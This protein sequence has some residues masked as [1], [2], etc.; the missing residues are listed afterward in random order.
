ML[1]DKHLLKEQPHP[2]GYIGGVQRIYRFDNGY[3]LSV[4][5]GA[6]LHAYP[7]AWEIAVLENVSEDGK[8]FNLTYDTELTKDVE[9]F[10]T[11][12]E[13]D[14]FINN[15]IEVLSIL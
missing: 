14:T 2:S 12:E 13:T 3:G 1:T 8:M 5:N 7:F 10:D 6:M 4:V 9:V 11:D 15:A